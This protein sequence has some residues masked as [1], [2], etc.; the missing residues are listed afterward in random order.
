MVKLFSFFF[1]VSL[2]QDVQRKVKK[3]LKVGMQKGTLGKCRNKADWEG[4]PASGEQQKKKKKRKILRSS[5]WKKE[6]PQN[7]A[8][9]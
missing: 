9:L 5:F 7:M 4:I 8:A 1:E 2:C 3:K 6:I